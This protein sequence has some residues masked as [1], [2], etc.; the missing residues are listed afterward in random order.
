LKGEKE[1]STKKQRK[2]LKSGFLAR[3]RIATLELLTGFA[4][5]RPLVFTFLPLHKWDCDFILFTF[6]GLA[7]TPGQGKHS[8]GACLFCPFKSLFSFNTKKRKD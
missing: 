4:P 3:C 1:Q 7:I 6:V 5:L 8:Q 2:P